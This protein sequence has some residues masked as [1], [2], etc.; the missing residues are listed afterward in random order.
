MPR[1]VHSVLVFL[2][3]TALG[4]EARADDPPTESSADAPRE[5]VIY[6]GFK[7]TEIVPSAQSILK[8]ARRCANAA[9]LRPEPPAPSTAPHLSATWADGEA[10]ALLERTVEISCRAEP[11]RRCRVTYAWQP[12]NVDLAYAAVQCFG[13]HDSAATSYLLTATLDLV[14]AKKAEVRGT[15]KDKAIHRV[16]LSLQT[17]EFPGTHL[18]ATGEVRRKNGEVVRRVLVQRFDDYQDTDTASTGSLDAPGLLRIAR[19]TTQT[20]CR[21][22]GE[23]GASKPRGRPLERP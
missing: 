4:L 13:S 11:V 10:V 3:L 9:S 6:P 20:A 5:V 2:S 1:L 15:S 8:A 17:T 19:D 7:K 12:D 16:G 18:A 23:C 22:V 21:L 14:K